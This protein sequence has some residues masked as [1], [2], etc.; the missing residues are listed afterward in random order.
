MT[1][2]RHRRDRRR[3]ACRRPGP[4]FRLSDSVSWQASSGHLLTP[5]SS[6]RLLRPFAPSSKSCSPAY[7]L[8]WGPDPTVG[9]TGGAPSAA[10]VGL[11]QTVVRGTLNS[12]A[13]YGETSGDSHGRQADQ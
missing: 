10:F 8:R 7:A 2:R 9:I 13:P 1:S 12:T 3:P 4:S 11:A 5:V 6:L